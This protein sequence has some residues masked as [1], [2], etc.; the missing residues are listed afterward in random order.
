MVPATAE[1]IFSVVVGLMRRG[2]F[3]WSAEVTDPASP[4]AGLTTGGPSRRAARR[5]IAI[6]VAHELGLCA[7]VPVRVEVIAWRSVIYSLRRR[8]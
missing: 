7:D 6:A 4:V 5:R 8:S 3:R 2:M 1:P